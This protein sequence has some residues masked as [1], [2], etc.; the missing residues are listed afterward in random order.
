MR[1]N[2]ATAQ[3]ARY[4]ARAAS[5]KNCNRCAVPEQEFPLTGKANASGNL[6]NRHPAVGST[7][8]IA[9]SR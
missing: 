8:A 4:W 3:S 6:A 9:A 2:G 5:G 1:R 7:S